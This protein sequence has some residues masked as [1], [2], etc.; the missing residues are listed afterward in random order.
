MD[1]KLAGTKKGITA[2][3]ADFK[4]PGLPLKIIME[5]VQQA[6]DAKSHI[7]DIMANTLSVPRT[8]KKDIWPVSEKLKV[9]AHKRA[10]FVG[11]GGVNIKK[12]TAE[13]GVQVKYQTKTNN[14]SGEAFLILIFCLFLFFPPMCM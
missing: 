13:A 11:I 8:D 5:A 4:L 14:N 10:K 12:L 2:L 7:L 6:T 3:Q 1:F 9:E